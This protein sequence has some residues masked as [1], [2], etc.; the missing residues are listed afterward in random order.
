MPTVTCRRAGGDTVDVNFF[1]GSDRKWRV[2]GP[3][4]VMRHIDGSN[5]ESTVRRWI[6]ETYDDRY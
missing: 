2:V 3:D 4:G 6:R 1:R 5:S